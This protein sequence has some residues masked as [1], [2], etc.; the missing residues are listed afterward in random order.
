MQERSKKRGKMR[1]WHGKKRVKLSPEAAKARKLLHEQFQAE[2]VV[3]RARAEA[4]LQDLRAVCSA[5]GAPMVKETKDEKTGAVVSRVRVQV[6]PRQCSIAL[7]GRQRSHG[8]VFEKQP[9][10]NQDVVKKILADKALEAKPVTP[11]MPATPSAT[12]PAGKTSAA[13]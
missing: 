4:L 5:C 11:A 3:E 2:L 6:C 12:P 9:L 8:V 1:V 7:L 10:P 13:P